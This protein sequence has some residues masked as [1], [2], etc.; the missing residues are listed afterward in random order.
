[1]LVQ[2]VFAEEPCTLV[3]MWGSDEEGPNTTANGVAIDSS[4]NIYVTDTGNNKIREFSS[5]GSMIAY[6]NLK[7]TEPGQVDVAS[8]CGIA[9]DSSRN[10]YITDR[11][12]NTVLKFT[13]RGSEIWGSE[14][15]G[16]GQ[17]SHPT[18]IAVDSA[19]NVYVAD[20]GN[21]RIQKFH[22]TGAFM[23][24]LGSYGTPDGSF[25]APMAVTVDSYGHVY[26]ADTGNTRIQK[27][28]PTGTFLA[29][30]GTSGTGDGQLPAPT[31]IAVD[32][33]DYIYVTGGSSRIQKFSPTG[34]YISTCD[35]GGST[36]TIAIDSSGYIYALWNNAP[37]WKLGVYRTPNSIPTQTTAPPKRTPRP[38]IIT[39]APIVPATS[40]NGAQQAEIPVT[41]TTS[42]TTVLNATPMTMISLTLTP[43]DDYNTT[44]AAPGD[45]PEGQAWKSDIQKDI[46]VRITQFF[47]DLF[48]RN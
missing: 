12:N 18:G 40:Q 8:A 14:G 27:F 3:R 15:T 46:L 11:E 10:V 4:G 21:N 20:T 30:W 16:D 22:S 28:S 24:V 7:G 6:W 37:F 35:A 48:G 23:A 25:N 47:R 5:D 32:S 17:F 13:T 44:M 31:G 42:L 1:M 33:W 19:G 38:M 34:E 29:K 45:L 26:V 9:V 41:T 43:A 2:G 36:N 39:P